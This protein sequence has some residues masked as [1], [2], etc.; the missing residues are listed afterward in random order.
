MKT[1]IK[2]TLIIA[3]IAMMGL[4]GIKY[5]Y[6]TVNDE[7]NIKKI[8]YAQNAL[9]RIDQE[10]ASDSLNPEER[11]ELMLTRSEIQ[12]EIN[13]YSKNK[14]HNN[15]ADVSALNARLNFARNTLARI[16]EELKSDTI[17]PEER[18]ELILTRINVQREIQELSRQLPN[19]AQPIVQPLPSREK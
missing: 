3:G 13:T 1:K 17:N 8:E 4:M 14:K 10:L 6:N 2:K 19:N 9:N 15:E 7:D 5:S 18:H 16:E 12:K 11:H